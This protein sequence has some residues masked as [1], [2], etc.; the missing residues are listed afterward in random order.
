MEEVFRK[1]KQEK[2]FFDA[3]CGFMKIHKFKRLYTFSKKKTEL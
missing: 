3:N 1:T 2:K